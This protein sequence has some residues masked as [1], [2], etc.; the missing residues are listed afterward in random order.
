MARF[1]GQHE[2][3]LGDVRAALAELDAIEAVT[4]DQ[5]KAVARKYLNKNQRSVVV[6]KPQ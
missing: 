4:A 3:V 1:I 6:G 2:L 5:V